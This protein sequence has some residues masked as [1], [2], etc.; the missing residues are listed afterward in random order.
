[1]LLTLR[2]TFN[3]LWVNKIFHNVLSKLVL[4]VC[5][6]TIMHDLAFFS[7]I[8]SNM[9]QAY[10]NFVHNYVLV[11]LNIHFWIPKPRLIDV[12]KALTTLW[13]VAQWT[14]QYRNRTQKYLQYSIT[15][16]FTLGIT[17]G[18]SFHQY[19]GFSLEGPK[20]LVNCD[21]LQNIHIIIRH[22]IRMGVL[23]LEPQVHILLQ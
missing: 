5:S 22:A 1:M 11:I 10:N 4:V 7:L 9:F 17:W 8:Y 12:W 14:H 18:T 19:V 23:Q 2:T 16:L 6:F 20:R 13:Y 3:L 21:F 15:T